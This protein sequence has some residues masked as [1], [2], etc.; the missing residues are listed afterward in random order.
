MKNL[1][2]QMLP[3]L[4]GN[5]KFSAVDAAFLAYLREELRVDTVWYT[6][7]I[8]HATRKADGGCIPSKVVKG[9]AGSPY[10]IADYYDT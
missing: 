7:V 2:Y 4:W 1:I 8:R 6:G 5:G 10:A 9:E 3:R